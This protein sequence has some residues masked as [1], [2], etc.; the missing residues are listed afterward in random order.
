M[1]FREFEHGWEVRVQWW[2]VLNPGM[3]PKRGV[4]H[5]RLRE[6]T[7]R[8]RYGATAL[9]RRTEERCLYFEH[10]G[11]EEEG[12]ASLDADAL[13]PRMPLVGEPT[14]E[15]L[16]LD[17]GLGGDAPTPAEATARRC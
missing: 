16:A 4:P 17:D 14:Y 9:V 8:L 6:S 11:E 13:R 2:S 3:L 7:T 15:V 1:R 12:A 5:A 10:G